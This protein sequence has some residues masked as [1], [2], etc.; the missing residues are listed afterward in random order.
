MVI[1]LGDAAEVL[2]DIKDGC[3]DLTVTSPPYDKIRTYSGYLYFDFKTIAKQLYRIIKNGG[4]VVWIVGDQT[5]N[6]DKTL[7]SFQQA[8]YFKSVGF[9]LHDT[10]IFLK[11][12]FGF[13]ETTRYHQVFEYMFILSKGKPDTFNP[14]FDRNNFSAGTRT[15]GKQMQRQPD[16]SLYHDYTKDKRLRGEI[17]MRWNVWYYPVGMINSTDDIIAFEHP[18]TMPDRLAEDHI[19][20]WSNEGDLILDPFAGSGTT[21][22]AAQQLNRKWIGIEINPDYVALAKK[23][24]TPYIQQQRLEQYI[25]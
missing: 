5:V 17:S 22:K 20:S 8:L 1:L 3:I 24:L 14:I 13:P 11:S 9:K 12:G 18:A 23:R 25:Q 16:G 21:L 2:R 15:R 19:K 4:V 6:G 7:T 10:M